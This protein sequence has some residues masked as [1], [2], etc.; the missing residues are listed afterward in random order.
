MCLVSGVVL[1]KGS[2]LPKSVSRKNCAQRVCSSVCLSV[3][4]QLHIHLNG[5]G[6]VRRCRNRAAK[7]RKQEEREKKHQNK[8][9]WLSGIKFREK[10]QVNRSN[11][12]LSL[13]VSCKYFPSFFFTTVQK[14]EAEDCNPYS[15]SHCKLYLSFFSCA[16][17]DVKLAWEDVYTTR[18]LRANRS[19][20]A[21]PS[22]VF[23][24]VSS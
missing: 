24:C 10:E 3:C 5:R 19:V 8:R 4:Y 14:C 12:I 20:T 17:R 1:N 15:T 9:N 21:R 18:L 13:R 6:K 22:F 11:M 2:P 23:L 7:Q 16:V